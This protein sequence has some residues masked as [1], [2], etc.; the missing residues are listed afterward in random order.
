MKVRMK[1]K[2]LIIVNP[3]A[4][5]GKGEKDWPFIQSQ[6]ENKELDYHYQFSEYHRHAIS[7]AR[8]GIEKGYRKLIAVGGDGTINEV[9]NG[10]FQQ[11]EVPSTE[12]TLGVITIGTGNDWG[13]MFNIPHDYEQ[14]IDTILQEKVFYHDA[15]LVTY[16][17]GK[18]DS[19]R[20]FINI[21]GLGFDAM[22]ARN[23][24]A[25]KEQDKG[26]SF[27]Y[28]S[29][30]LSGLIQYKH[31][32]SIIHLDDPTHTVNI[33]LFSMN[34]GICQY[35]GGGMRQVPN[36]I[37]DDGLFDLTIIGKMRKLDV[38]WH[39]RKLYKGS[40]LK[41]PFVKSFRGKSVKIDSPSKIWLEVDGE[42]LGHTPLSFE[43]IPQ[44][45]KVI[46]GK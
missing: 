37:P 9:V 3:N 1:N 29:S 27:S 26:N 13:R 6:V 19:R 5:T 30:L 44:S 43:I 2:W 39:I 32:K 23:T 8:E 46:V 33:D 21:A 15:G 4:G 20:Y 18:S 41:L 22:V 38:L 24:N 12:I 14:A 31:Q 11:S 10:I 28:L 36:A 40:H 45:I 7:L 42:S 34:V 16:Q 35:N 25:L 17:N